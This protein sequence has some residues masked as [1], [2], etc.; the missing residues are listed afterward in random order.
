MNDGL[1][2]TPAV[3][4]WCREGPESVRKRGVQGGRGEL[5]GRVMG[6]TPPDGICVPR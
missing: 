3:R 4:Q 1:G 6:W 2:S 5:P